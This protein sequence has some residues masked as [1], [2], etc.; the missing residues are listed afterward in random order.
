[1]TWNLAYAHLLY[2]ILNDAE[3]LDDFNAAINRRYPKKSGIQIAAYDHFMEELKESEVV[4][5][6]KTRW[7]INANIARILREKLDKRNTAAHPASVVIVQAQADDAV[8]DLVNNVV[9]CLQ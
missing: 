9:L 5:I 4:E 8:T 3:R 6:C 2:W 1:M 7:L